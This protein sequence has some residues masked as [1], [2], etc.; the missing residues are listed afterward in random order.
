MKIN[1]AYSIYLL[2]LVQYFKQ[3]FYND[4]NYLEKIHSKD[5]KYTK[6]SIKSNH[7]IHIEII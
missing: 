5:T 1:I 7:R 6:S 4:T 3:Y 2:L